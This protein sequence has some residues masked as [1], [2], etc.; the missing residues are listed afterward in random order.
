MI[1][2]KRRFGW[3]IELAHPG[4]IV[5]VW[6]AV[7]IGGGSLLLRHPLAHQAQT[8]SWG[9]ATFTAASAV[10]V[11]GLSVVDTGTVWSLWG[12]FVLLALIQVGG[13]GVMTMAA[14]FGIVL[15]RKL[16]VRSGM[17]AGAETGLTDLGL[18]R[19]LIRDMVLF[20]VGAELLVAVLLTFGFWRTSESLAHSVHLGV[21]HAVSAFNNAGFSIIPGGLEGF[22]DDWWV[23]LVV[24][25]AFIVGG[26]G[27]PTVFEVLGCW[28]H[29]SRLSLHAKVTLSATGVLLVGGA[30]LIGVAEW[31]NPST[32]AP[33][34]PED[35]VL[36]SFFQSATARTAG[37]NTV[38]LSDL[39]PATTLVFLVLMLIGAGST[40]TGGGV[41]VTTVVVVW[42]TWLAEMR[43]DS[44]VDVF[45]RRIPTGVQRQALAL[46]AAAVSAVIAGALVLTL[47][48]PRLPLGVVLFESASAF[49]TV[50]V[51]AGA[52]S[53]FDGW[54]RVVL[55]LLMF[56][57]R[58]G[59]TT[60][61][62][63]VLMRRRRRNFDYPQEPLIVG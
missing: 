41:K 37:F 8:V 22:V 35:R 12:E 26:L 16:G 62:A 11:T 9:E 23:S 53:E 38:A 50:G 40:S 6:F 24:C 21:F 34:S 31:S 18:L 7:L 52:T 4:L 59:P 60:F 36:A 29:R 57:G 42:R 27:F 19:T 10:T 63:A 55:M 44:E 30:L 14:F 2:R 32:L 43:G 25:A 49:G 58:V 48:E 17:L 45:G 28:R 39:A 54:G 3:P 5:V 20:V 1:V 15:H 46:L 13:L 56:I 51:T 47:L 33:L 61:G